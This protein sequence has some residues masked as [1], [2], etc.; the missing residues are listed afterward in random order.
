[1]SGVTST[2]VPG[3]HGP[4]PVRVYNPD[5]SPVAGLVWA[6]GG[7]YVAGDLDMPEADQVGRRL[8]EGGI[9]CVSVDYRL[10]PLSPEWAAEAGLEPRPGVH[11]PVPMDDVLAAFQWARDENTN[12]RLPWSIGGASA[13]S[14]LAA[15]AALKLRDID[16]SP[17][18]VVLAYPIVHAELPP[19]SA[20][21]AETMSKVPVERRFPSA[22]VERMT[23][24][25]IGAGDLRTAYAFAGDADVSGLPPVFV[26]NSE[27]D[28]LRASGERLTADLALAGV[29][30]LQVV[31]RGTFHGHLSELDDPL[32]LL[33]IGRILG[34]LRGGPQI[35]P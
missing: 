32:A 21:L 25:Y 7:S 15:A 28:D 20:E 12:R 18:S 16:Q 10:A 24:N 31:E 8:A 22:A 1:M 26:L 17:A 35:A 2:A 27:F 11:F 4:I 30:V 13:G 5:G 6:H 3:P 19:L 23:A 34:W 14:A 29:D 33:S 9:L